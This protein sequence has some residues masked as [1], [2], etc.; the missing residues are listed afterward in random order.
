MWHLCHT[1]G[2]TVMKEQTLYQLTIDGFTNGPSTKEAAVIK[3]VI[4]AMWYPTNNMYLMK[5]LI[6]CQNLYMY[7]YSSYMQLCIHRLHTYV[8][9]LFTYVYMYVCIHICICIHYV[10]I[11]LYIQ[12]CIHTVR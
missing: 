5:F 12:L 11:H 8:Y 6:F 4:H 7:A 3:N 9:I 10:C 2:V 1:L